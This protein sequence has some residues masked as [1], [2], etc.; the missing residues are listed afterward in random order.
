MKDYL[1]N[2]WNALW[3][4][5]T[6]DEELKSRYDEVVKELEDVKVSAKQVVKQSKDVVKAAKGKKR[7]GRKPKK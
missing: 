6:I 3:A 2:L 1:K 4:K 5:T 7:R